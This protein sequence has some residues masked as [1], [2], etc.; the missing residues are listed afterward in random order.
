MSEIVGKKI[1]LRP[2]VESDTA[3]ILRWRNSEL[4]RSNFIYQ[5]QLTQEGHLKWLHTKVNT[6]EVVQFIIVERDT[7]C[8]IGSAYLRD[9]DMMVKKAEYGMFIGEKQ[10]HGKGYGTEA[11]QLTLQYAF[12]VLGLHKVSMR[13]LQGNEGSIH[14]CEKA[15]FLRE[16]YMVDE[17]FIG[18]EYRDVIFMAVV[19]K[20]GEQH[21]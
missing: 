9:I 16:G 17:V 13:V 10:A 12:D 1:I 15:G 21:E 4:V 19:S 5:T 2:I 20:E 7:A 6:G 8:P 18:D 11:A 14:A 3:N